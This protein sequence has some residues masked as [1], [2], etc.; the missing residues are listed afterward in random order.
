MPVD[1]AP[2]PTTN[3]APFWPAWTLTLDA[4]IR[5]LA[6]ARL[7]CRTCAV[8]LRVDPVELRRGLGGRGSLINRT[9]P[10]P[11]VSCDGR[12]Y[13]LAAP[14]TACAYHVLLDDPAL[15]KGV[16]DPVGAPF[17]SRWRDLVLVAGPPLPC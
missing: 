1:A 5:T 10:C 6:R 13:Y 4:M 14:G 9:V 11:V 3:V 8:L 12:A 2:L 7:R 15:L 17:R 16:V